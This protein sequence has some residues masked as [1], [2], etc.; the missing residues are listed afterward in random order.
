VNSLAGA[1]LFFFTCAVTA[2]VNWTK[3]FL[4]YLVPYVVSTYGA[5]SYRMSRPLT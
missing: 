5:V 2:T 1:K 4:T 3:I